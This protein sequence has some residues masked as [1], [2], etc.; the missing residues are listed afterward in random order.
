VIQIWE[1]AEGVEFAVRL[2][3]RASR[4][5]VGGEWQGA[6]KV[7]LTAPPVDDRANHALR[8]FL[9]SEL[10]VAGSAVTIIS[11]AHN[12]MK[13]LRIRGVSAE[14]VRGLQAQT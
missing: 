3:P 7:R 12:R 11:G 10:G 14:M 8:K 9:A 2:T 13:R 5:A 6:L 4:D 1:R